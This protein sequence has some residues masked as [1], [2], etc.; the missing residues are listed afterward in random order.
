MEEE[1]SPQENG[2]LNPRDSDRQLRLRLCVLNEILNTERD[3]VR[4]LVFLQS[5]SFYKFCHK[6][7]NNNP[8]VSLTCQI[9]KVVFSTFISHLKHGTWSRLTLDYEVAVDHSKVLTALKS[10]ERLH[11][12]ALSCQ[13]NPKWHWL[14]K[15]MAK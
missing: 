2:I 1:D 3:Y 10:D 11:A 6:N 9:E 14:M 4:T 15:L 8:I 12:L 5:V 13:C 7:T